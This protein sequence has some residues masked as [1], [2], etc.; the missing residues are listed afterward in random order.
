MSASSVKPP[1]VPPRWFIH[2]AWKT[3]RAIY[4]I[5]RGRLGVWRPKPGSWGALH[6]TTIGRRTGIRRSV[7]VGYFVE[8]TSFVTLAMNGWGAPEP[9][10]W[11]NLQA[12][13]SASVV[14]PNWSGRVLAHAATGDERDRLWA[15]WREI[16][17][18]L[19]GLAAMRPGP[20]AVV[21]LEP[22]P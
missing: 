20:T 8:E 21:I 14:T 6:L 19:D 16:D 10:W 4:R 15:R 22:Q 5:T 17:K 13:P 11:L 18:G 2:V 3:H 1:R 7:M 9:A 12:D